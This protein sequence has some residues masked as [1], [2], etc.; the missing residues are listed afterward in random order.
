MR[1]GSG[2]GGAEKENYLGKGKARLEEGE[3]EVWLTKVGEGLC[4]VLDFLDLGFEYFLYKGEV[5]NGCAQQNNSSLGDPGDAAGERVVWARAKLVG[6]PDAGFGASSRGNCC[7]SGEEKAAPRPLIE[8]DVDNGAE[9]IKLAYSVA[10]VVEP[11][12]SIKVRDLLDNHFYYRLEGEREEVASKRVA[13]LNSG[14]AEKG[15]RA[16]LEV[17]G[18]AVAL[19][20]VLCIQ[21]IQ[22][23]VYTLYS[24]QYTIYSV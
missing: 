5:P 23:I 20:I 17:R 19:S 16:K 3:F 2:V 7:C 22:S 13:L 12:M 10:I 1:E 21:S 4:D 11:D 6:T 8:D 24:V 9:V 15:M 14:A 18:G